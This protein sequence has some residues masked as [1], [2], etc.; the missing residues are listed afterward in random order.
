[1]PVTGLTLNGTGAGRRRVNIA[2]GA[3]PVGGDFRSQLVWSPVPVGTSRAAALNEW[4][5]GR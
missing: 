3:G 5:A 2:R 4:H 1:M